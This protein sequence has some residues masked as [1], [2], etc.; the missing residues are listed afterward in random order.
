MTPLKIPTDLPTH[1][2]TWLQYLDSAI[3]ERVGPEMADR[4]DKAGRQYRMMPRRLTWP[5][6][7][8]YFLELYASMLSD[9]QFESAKRAAVRVWPRIPERE[10]A[11]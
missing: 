5:A 10:V 7:A 1:T 3:A 4:I 11:A 9:Q 8:A 6:N 2:R